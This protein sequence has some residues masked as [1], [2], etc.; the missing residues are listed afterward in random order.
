[1]NDE[2]NKKVLE[3]RA[4][5]A[6]N[7]KKIVYNANSTLTDESRLARI[8]ETVFKE[9]YVNALRVG[10]PYAIKEL[11]HL[12]GG[13]NRKAIIVDENDEKIFILPPLTRSPNLADVGM[14]KTAP[15]ASLG[16]TIINKNSSKPGSGE[17]TLNNFIDN[18]MLD[19]E[20]LIVENQKSLQEEW[21]LV[22]E[23]YPKTD[24][25]DN[26]GGDYKEYVEVIDEE[27]TTDDTNTSFNNQDNSLDD[28]YE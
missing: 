23:R 26:E 18:T 9:R 7:I 3:L 2:Q 6:A 12:V 5:E 28:E 14:M 27:I 13:D 17:E 25:D 4:K 10:H 21:R 8:P 22:F 19:Y 1:M 11:T 16:D 20:D 15:V 24:P